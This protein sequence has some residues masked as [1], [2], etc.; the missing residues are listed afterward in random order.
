M[1]KS[2]VILANGEEKYIIK[3]G[4]PKEYLRRENHDGNQFN[5]EYAVKFIKP[6][7]N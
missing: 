6:A 5:C 2:L 1:E 4:I 3:A 7:D